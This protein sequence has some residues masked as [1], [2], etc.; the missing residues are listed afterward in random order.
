MTVTIPLLH[1]LLTNPTQHEAH[2]HSIPIEQRIPSLSSIVLSRPE[3]EDVGLLA[4]T[5]LRRD[6]SRMTA[7]ANSGASNIHS[8]AVN[9]NELVEPLMN[10][11]ESNWGREGTRRMVGRC[12][13]ELSCGGE[14]MAGVL[15]RLEGGVSVCSV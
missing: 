15:K 3:E 2:F 11:F 9:L 7:A 4:V 5:L 14:V 8:A 6:L 12:V 1:S 13:A 10:L